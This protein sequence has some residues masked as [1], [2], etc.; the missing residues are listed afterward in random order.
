MSAYR[1]LI[2]A[3]G[4]GSNAENIVRYFREKE[5]RGEGRVEI[6]GILTNNAHAGVIERADRLGIPCEIFNREHWKNSDSMLELV[7]KYN[8]DLIV[9][10][11]F[12]WKF[13]DF[14]IAQSKGK[15]INLHPALLPKFGGKGMYGM[16]VHEAVVAQG[17]TE[18]GI[19]VHWVNE[20]YDEGNIIAQLSC[21]VENG[22]TA[23]DVAEKIHQLEGAHFPAVVD[24]VLQ[25][26]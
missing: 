26:L 5:L 23:S 11:G 12:L 20:H 8:A 7:G 4:S 17:E 14:L 1:I 19:T 25:Q 2:F 24:S 3:S 15:V 9:L 13:P 6:V 18:T 22:D 16:H 21:K 10:A